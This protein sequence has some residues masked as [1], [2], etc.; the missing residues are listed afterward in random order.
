[1]SIFN[2]PAS[3]SSWL[4][5]FMRTKMNIAPN[6]PSMTWQL[7]RI[8][9]EIRWKRI[10]RSAQVRSSRAP[11]VLMTRWSCW[12]LAEP[13]SWD[14]HFARGC[15]QDVCYIYLI[16]LSFPHAYQR[17]LTRAQ[18]CRRRSAL[19]IVWSRRH[20]VSSQRFRRA[21]HHH[22]PGHDANSSWSEEERQASL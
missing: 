14:S 8:S 20:Q 16:V 5:S 2:P 13:N 15:L 7:S 12:H 19:C 18:W 9:L 17:V 22:R 3:N 11:T 4:V 6:T 21:H 1:M 10:S